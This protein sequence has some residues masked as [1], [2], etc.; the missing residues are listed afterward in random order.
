VRLPPFDWWRSIFFLL[1]VITVCT[2]FLGTLSLLSTFF[3]RRGAFAHRCARWWSQ[4]IL[5]VSGVRVEE[6]GTLPAGDTSC[7]FVAN[8]A[9]F[10]DIPILFATVP[11]PLRIIAK[12]ALGRVPFIGW[13]L[14]RAGHLLVDRTNPG[15]AI[16]KKMQR[17]T[18]DGASLI[19]FPEGSRSR[20][21]ELGKFKG[22]VFL[23][24]LETGLPIVPIS[25]S[26]SRAVMPPGRVAV[27]PSHVCVTMH[28]PIATTGMTREDARA[29][30]ARV[31]E[32]VASAL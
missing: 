12:A 11:R 18:A 23:L 16:V 20:N 30:A 28:E 7:V 13:H 15:A 2:V 5:G 8:H 22:G 10:F 6:R 32:V 1:P 24:A 3:D 25:V 4:A 17:M 29:L 27:H 9:S 31:R 26:G 19:V 21:G 14:R